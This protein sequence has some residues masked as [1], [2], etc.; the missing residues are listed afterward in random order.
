MATV[1]FV[2]D[3]DHTRMLVEHILR[4]AGHEVIL[5]ASADEALAC[6]ERPP[7][8]DILI[9]DIAMPGRNGL[10]LLRAVRATVWGHQL[11]FVF[12]TAHP[13]ASNR[14]EAEKGQANGFLVKPIEPNAL[15]AVVASLVNNGA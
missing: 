11:P 2:D 15:R 4:R 13:L 12:L 14:R 8:P 3:D 7:R 6:L 1:L 5:A 10:E 9:A